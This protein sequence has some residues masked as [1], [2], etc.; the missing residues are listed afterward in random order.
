MPLNVST[1][2]QL[3]QQLED[4]ELHV[5]WQLS[6]QLAGAVLLGALEARRRRAERRRHSRLYLCR[7]QLLPNPRVETPWQQLYASQ[8]NRAFITTMGFDTDTFDKILHGGFRAT[9]NGMTIPRR[10][11]S[12]TGN[13]RL[14]ARSL[15]AAGALGL[16]LHYLNSTMRE[17]SLQQIF[18]L[19]PTS[20][21]RYITFG[22][23]ILLGVLKKLPKAHI[24]WPRTD[25]DFDE[26]N[27]LIIARHSR[28]TGA[29]ATIDGLNL[30]VETAEDEELE[31]ATYNGWKCDHF[32]SSVLVFSPKVQ[33]P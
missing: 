25:S 24:S 19:I 31:N 33:G 13:P 10:D 5:E 7:P 3:L 11:V 23:Q 26:F 6:Q 1:A 18:A 30:P 32:I 29:F 9:W 16:V 22:L 17:I 15:D 21:S 14:G 27:S 12:L 28:L 2:F 20:V 4:T 8:N